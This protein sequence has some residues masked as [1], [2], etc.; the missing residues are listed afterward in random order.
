MEMLTFTDRVAVVTGA[1]R[2][3]GRAHALLLASRGAAVVVNDLGIAVDG[4]G[5]SAQ[6]ADDVTAEIQGAGGTAEADNHD[7]STEAGSNALIDH[8]MDRFGRVDVLVHNAGFNIGDLRPIFDVH[9]GAAWWLTERAWPYLVNQGYG[10]LVL[11]TSASVFGDG[12]G[13]GRNPKQA[14][15]M[16]KAAVLG[17]TTSLAAR[18]RPAGIKVNALLPSAFTRLVGMNKG[19]NTTR[20]DAV[21]IERAIEWSEAHSPAH[22]VAAGALWLM[23]E[24]CPVSGRF[25]AA[26]SGRV[27]EVV[28]GVTKGYVAVDGDLAPE[29]VVEHLDAVRDQTGYIVPVDMY[30]Y[31]AWHHRLVEGDLAKSS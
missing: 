9:V 30:D 18:G 1:G 16:A 25:F 6:P 2:G 15:S 19:I 12:T 24:S 26:G 20:P 5:S 8:A 28:L 31:S 22:L 14:Y 27:S 17:L 4:T 21:P 13:P 23:H 3:I 29:D 11:T 10:R 7:V